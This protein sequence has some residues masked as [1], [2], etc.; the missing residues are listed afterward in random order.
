MR[1]IV[2]VETQEEHD[3]W[4]AK[5]QSYYAQNHPETVPAANPGAETTQPVVDS[6]KK[7]TMK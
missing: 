7:I 3:A 1:A 6:S 2:I 4:L 5:Q